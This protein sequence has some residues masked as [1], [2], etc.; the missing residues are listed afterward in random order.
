MTRKPIIAGLSLMAIGAIVMAQNAVFPSAVV[1]DNQLMK[2]SNNYVGATLSSSIGASDTSVIVSST[3]GLAF[4]ALITFSDSPEIAAVCNITGNTLVFGYGGSCPSVNGRG[5]DGTTAAGHAASA[6]VGAFMDAWHRN[7]D[8]VE[9]ESIETTLGANLSNLNVNSANAYN[10]PV[11]NPGGSLNAGNNAVLMVPVPA[12]VNGSDTGHY[13]YVSGGT[14]TAEPCLITGGS[15]TSGQPSGQIIINCGNT[16]TGAWGITSATVGIC[17]GLNALT[18]HIGRVTLSA[19]SFS[20]HAP[21]PMLSNQAVTG[22]SLYTTT[23]NVAADF[24]LSTNGVF[25]GPTPTTGNGPQITDLTVAFTQPDSAA[26]GAYTHWPAAFY[27][28]STGRFRIAN[29]QVLQAWDGINMT[30]NSGGSIISNFQ[31]SAFNKSISIDGSFDSVYLTGVRCWPYTL[32]NNQQTVFFTNSGTTCLNS[33]RMDDIHVTDFFA[34]TTHG[35]NIFAGI[36]GTT[37]GS[38]E[39]VWLD[40]NSDF[41]IAGGAQIRISNMNVS[42]LRMGSNTVMPITGSSTNVQITNSFFFPGATPSGTNPWIS[43]SGGALLQ[44][45]NS[46][47]W[48]ATVDINSLLMSGSG[49]LIATDNW[50][51]RDASTA[52]TR[53]TINVTGGRATLT[54]NRTSDMGVGSGTFISLSTDD[55]HQVRDNTGPGW[56]MSFPLP[57]GTPK[58]VYESDAS[59]GGTARLAQ[60]YWGNGSPNSAVTAN[61][62]A[63]YLNISGG[64]SVTLWVKETGTNTNTG[65]VAK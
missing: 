9:I 21:V 60:M 15:G 12:G 61:P 48:S 52:Y 50:F 54:G 41:P 45:S 46:W 14:G 26:I 34:D 7:T 13:L 11:Q 1:T 27:M 36:S 47:F 65:W 17:E 53:P 29:V 20:M 3:Q 22:A 5:F 18:S 19:G 64:T 44:I 24:P 31:I 49:T 16:H 59:L 10:F 39:N 43:V 23:L 2:A 35:V 28:V 55:W 62:G 8:R 30:G 40:T 57:S 58:G 38:F 33:G 25:I 42:Y 51:L 32:T 56:A 37:A 63:I 6:K 4:P